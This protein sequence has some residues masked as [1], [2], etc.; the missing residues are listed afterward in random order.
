MNVDFQAVPEFFRGQPIAAEDLNN[1]Y[2]N[3]TTAKNLLNSPQPLFM[4]SHAY[5]P[6]ILPLTWR[7]PDYDIWKGSFMYREGMKN[8]YLGFHIKLDSGLHNVNNEYNYTQFTDISVAVIVKYTSFTYQ[9]IY[10]NNQFSKYCAARPLNTL[11]TYT[12]AKSGISYEFIIKDGHANNDPNNKETILGTEVIKRD[13]RMS[14]LTISLDNMG[15]Q[16]GEIVE[17]K[18]VLVTHSDPT[19]L[20][21]RGNGYDSFFNKF[22][23]KAKFSGFNVANSHIFYSML[24]AKVDGDLSYTANW[25]TTAF[26][27]TGNNVLSPNNLAILTQKQ[28]Y[29]V[30]R[31][32]NRPMPMT[33]SIVYIGA[34]GGTASSRLLEQDIVKGEWDYF[35]EN[36]WL[37]TDNRGTSLITKDDNID[38]VGKML[39]MNRSFNAQTNLATFAWSPYFDVYNTLYLNFR[40][41]GNTESRQF[42]MLDMPDQPV[43]QT[44]TRRSYLYWPNTDGRLSSHIVGH[45][46][47][48]TLYGSIFGK[49]ETVTSSFTSSNLKTYLNKMYNVRIPS[50]T[51]PVFSPEFQTNSL[52]HTGTYS[53][54]YLTQG[55]WEDSVAI[56]F[57]KTAESGIYEKWGLLKAQG[58]NETIQYGFV[59]DASLNDAMGDYVNKITVSNTTQE[60][61]LQYTQVTQYNDSNYKWIFKNKSKGY[62]QI[63]VNLYDHFSRTLQTKANYISYCQILGMTVSNPD[64][65][66]Y[67]APTKLEPTIQM[68]YSGLVNHLSVIN[69]TIT[70]V[71]S[72]MFLV[73][74]HFKYYDMF[75]GRP[76]SILNNAGMFK[77][78]NEKF[79]FFTKQRIGNI[80]I[81]RG[82]NVTLYYGEIEELR[83]ETDPKGSLVPDGSVDI[84]IAKSQQIISG[85]AEQTVI[86]HLDSID[87]LA[88]GQYYYLKGDSIIYASEF[89]EEPS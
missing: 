75:W 66:M 80:L 61:D 36:Y 57:E 44:S 5:A 88:Y 69:T 54:F 14:S 70:N 64:N 3:N 60:K 67:D 22:F 48:Q 29:V 43:S 18:L 56:V 34:W 85:D 2:H 30:E 33:G 65:R 4:D 6:K 86:F 63:Y 32:R 23:W 10:S 7:S 11:G 8:A 26:T 83:R 19:I 49:H 55:M 46:Q 47:T 9:S 1:F 28:K 21:S 15:L 37:P 87:D 73:N 74:P 53:K 62:S 20:A 82:K 45:Y 68:A 12:V 59:G 89:Y 41:Y 39:D 77:E 78:Y 13:S 81:A 72:D 16:D 42:I 84:T 40:F 17:V 35:I 31:L 51:T 58:D 27:T 24:Y 71:Y 79:F 52:N 25:P 38:D 76:I 50:P